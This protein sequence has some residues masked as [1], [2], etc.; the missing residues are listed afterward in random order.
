MAPGA[1]LRRV[2]RRLTLAHF[3]GVCFLGAVGIILLLFT[4]PV[5]PLPL[6][7][8]TLIAAAMLVLGMPVAA[9]VPQL[10]R[11]ERTVARLERGSPLTDAEVRAYQ[12]WL[13]THPLRAAAVGVLATTAAYAAGAVWLRATHVVPWDAITI[14]I[15]CGVL[16]GLMW[17]I[18]VY[19]LSEY[20]L[21]PLTALAPVVRAPGRRI[22]L[23]A[24]IF[25]SAVTVLTS[26]LGLF[27]LM[28]YTRAA[29]IVERQVGELVHTRVTE[30]ADIF[31]ANPAPDDQ[32]PSDAWV[33]AAGAVRVSAGTTYHVVD[34]GGRILATYPPNAARVRHLEEAPLQRD[35]VAQIL[36]DQEAFLTDRFDWNK[37]VAFVPIPDHFTWKLLALTPRADFSAEINQ[38][39]YSA[40]ASMAFSML[41]A[42]G[43]AYLST[44]SVTTPLRQVTHAAQAMAT[45]R[46]LAQRVPFLTNDEV[47]ELGRAFN[48]MAATIQ[49]YAEG[50]E[51][52]V[53]AR[54]RELEDKNQQLELRTQEVEAKSQEMRD[55]LYVVS[56]DL[57]AP[58]INVQG[59]TTALQENVNEVE[60]LAV[61][62]PA[63]KAERWAALRAEMTQSLHFIL[64]GAAKMDGLIKAL[65]QLSRIESRPRTAER[66][67]TEKL[68][69]DIVA[70][71][72]YQARARGI[73]ITVGPLP[74][75]VGDPVQINQVFSNLID[76]AIKY[77]SG[78][79]EKRIEVGAE[80]ND[81][82]HR[83]FV[84][85]TGPGIRP[86]DQAKVFRL[87]ARV[88]DSRDVPG[89]GIGL[90]A[91]K[92][93]IEKH[94]GT[95]GV[96]STVGAGSTFWF[97]LPTDG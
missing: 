53:A 80:P 61:Q 48:H 94:G 7:E 10:R 13:L 35:V 49:Q 11:I 66:I 71:L 59:F 82:G 37:M 12:T 16:S 77:M 2:R 9:R 3:A 86:E 65:L 23:G 34:G 8:W 51:E 76:N 67:E 33:F 58:L 56:H 69:R 92:K 19:F 44:R 89:E 72:E 81:D 27:G 55:F 41:L 1:A 6:R 73:A 31:A 63:D 17:A 45:Q 78:D 84:R 93:I 79:G 68:V 20:E 74:P 36:N 88:G 95:I 90:A 91:V 85:D 40:L 47:G 70:A 54:T 18:I 15:V 4:L 83:F 62:A 60:R 32:H 25:V 22:P 52:L 75:V 96:E 42:F 39:I 5:N 97:T 46:D 38:F 43:I 26:A 14:M 21:R 50:L 87:F 57:R 28:T 30:L 64:R 29:R 24:K